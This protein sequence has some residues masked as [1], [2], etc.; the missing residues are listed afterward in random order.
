M[1][2]GFKISPSEISAATPIQWRWMNLCLCSSKHRKLT[3]ERFICSEIPLT[4]IVFA[5]QQSFQRVKQNHYTGLL[6]WERWKTWPS[7]NLGELTLLKILCIFIFDV[8]FHIIHLW[9]HAYYKGILVACT[10][11][12][13]KTIFPDIID[14]IWSDIFPHRSLAP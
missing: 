2:W 3:Y 4:S 12:R 13:C 8:L 1:C 10:L 7:C 9:P 6:L 11:Y 14:W 5:W